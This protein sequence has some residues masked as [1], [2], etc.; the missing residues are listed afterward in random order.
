MHRPPSQKQH[1][2]SLRERQAWRLHQSVYNPV[3]KELESTLTVVEHK[4]QQ[5]P[6]VRQE[7]HT[8]R[9]IGLHRVR[10]AAPVLVSSKTATP[11]RWTQPVEQRLDP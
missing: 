6:R 9:A 3:D 2:N 10:A 4:T 7:W 5:Q 8:T 11:I 1:P